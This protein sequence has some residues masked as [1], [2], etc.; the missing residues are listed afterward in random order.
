MHNHYNAIFPDKE[1]DCSA[2]VFAGLISS[3]D[4][5]DLFLFD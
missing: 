1:D 2:I 3:F 5:G 4:R